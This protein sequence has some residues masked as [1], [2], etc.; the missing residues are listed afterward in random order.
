[1]DL[2]KA[3]VGMATVPMRAGLAAADLGLGVAE[4]GIELAKRSLTDA[5]V[6]MGPSSVAQVFGLEDTISRA[7][8][9]AQLV[10][11]DAP[12]GRALAPDGPLDRLM[13]PGGLIDRLTAPDGV[14]DRMT[15]EGGGLDRALAPGGLVDR[16]LAEDGLL[17]RVLAEAAFAGLPTGPGKSRK[18]ASRIPS[19]W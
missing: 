10:D 16:L 7:N 4:A 12:L 5:G 13:R 17:E 8:R 15:A 6:P 3:L 2:A 18:K 19:C 9:I 11:E 14:L 1:M